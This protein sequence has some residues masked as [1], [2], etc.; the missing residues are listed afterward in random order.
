MTLNS[1]KKGEDFVFL[2]DKQLLA[3]D[4]GNVEVGPK[5][6]PVVLELV[7]WCRPGFGDSGHQLYLMPP[8][9][10]FLCC[11]R[12]AVYHAPH[13]INANTLQRRRK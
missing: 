7:F 8:I 2:L 13:S 6:C 4:A 12:L 11:E 3:L 5:C 10:C 1:N 9:V